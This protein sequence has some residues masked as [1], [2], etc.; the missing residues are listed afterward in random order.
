MLLESSPGDTV[1]VP[2]PKLSFG[3]KLQGSVGRGRG[4]RGRGVPW[5]LQLVKSVETS[6]VS[7]IIFF[8]VYFEIIKTYLSHINS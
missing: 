3:T 6:R 4:E 8:N 5:D 7:N 2:V 1:P